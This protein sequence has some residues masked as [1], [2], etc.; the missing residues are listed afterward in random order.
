MT[1]TSFSVEFPVKYIMLKREDYKEV[2]P[3]SSLFF[4]HPLP[5]CGLFFTPPISRTFHTFRPRIPRAFLSQ[6]GQS[7]RRL[8]SHCS[9]A[10]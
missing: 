10:M 8:L 5:R 7:E 2:W 1:F 3:S 6:Q 9:S 4:A